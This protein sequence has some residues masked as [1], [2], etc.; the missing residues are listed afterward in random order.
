ML[1]RRASYGGLELSLEQLHDDGAVE[2]FV[3]VPGDAG[4]F[5]VRDLA[6]VGLLHV[7]PLGH[8]F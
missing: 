7:H 2:A 5:L 3:V 8:L 4:A 6:K 1:A